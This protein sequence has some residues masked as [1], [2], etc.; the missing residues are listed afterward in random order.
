MERPPVRPTIV[1][2]RGYCKA[3][4][5]NSLSAFRSAELVG[6]EWVECDVHAAANGTPI[7]IHD[8][9]L[10]RTTSGDGA[11]ADKLS[12]ELAHLRLKFNEQLT[13]EPVPTLARLLAAL[14]PGTGILVE[15]KPP[16]DSR[17]VADVVAMLRAERRPWVVQSFDA[18][19][20]LEV[21]ARDRGAPAALLVED[22]RVLSRAVDECWRGVNVD[23]AL[24]NADVVAALRAKHRSVGAWTV[25]AAED[26][27]RIVSLGV[28]WLI[29]DEPLLAREICRELCEPVAP[30][31][32]PRQ[33]A[34]PR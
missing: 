1:A 18:A 12:S 30:T 32:A 2:H 9:T 27:R 33:F 20:V 24:L 29:T 34:R 8:E 23:H 3:H 11:V 13:G 10:E 6:C 31:E 21:C 4:P 25:N 16:G 7:V 14:R 5:E 19:N 26:I 15:I 22:P 28:D 17:L